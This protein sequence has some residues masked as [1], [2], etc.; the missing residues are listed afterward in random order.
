[1]CVYGY[2]LGPCIQSNDARSVRLSHDS[3]PSYIWHVQ[4]QAHSQGMMRLT[5]QCEFITGMTH[6]K[7]HTHTHC[8]LTAIGCLSPMLTSQTHTHTHKWML[9]S[10]LFTPSALCWSDSIFLSLFLVLLQT[11]YYTQSVH[12]LVLFR[13]SLCQ[14]SDTVC[15]LVTFNISC[16]G[17]LTGCTGRK[18]DALD[19]TVQRTTLTLPVDCPHFVS[20][21]HVYLYQDHSSLFNLCVC[22][23]VWFV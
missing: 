23:R 8:A 6:L 16:W 22:M 12:C 18:W 21:T 2:R 14:N 15:A 11:Y 17:A 1:M 7:Q 10:S 9:H 4:P 20:I 13:P 19:T 5:D 3:P